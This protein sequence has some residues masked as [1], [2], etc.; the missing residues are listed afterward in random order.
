MNLVGMV[1]SYSKDT[2]PCGRGS[3]FTFGHSKRDSVGSPILRMS[4]QRTCPSVLVEKHSVPVEILAWIL[5]LVGKFMGI[6]ILVSGIATTNVTKTRRQVSLYKGSGHSHTT[7][8]IISN[9]WRVNEALIKSLKVSSCFNWLSS[10]LVQVFL[11]MSTF[12]LVFLMHSFGFTIL[13]IMF[14]RGGTEGNLGTKGWAIYGW[15]EKV[16]KVGFKN[17]EK[18]NCAFCAKEKNEAWQPGQVKW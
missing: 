3:F 14:I 13:W 12:C 17:W 1:G 2:P 7:L 15:W 5:V 4:H 11:G 16:W 18:K 6:L 10:R 8:P 9:D